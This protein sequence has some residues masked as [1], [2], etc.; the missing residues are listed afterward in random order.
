MNPPAQIEKITIMKINAAMD[1]II[2]PAIFYLF[3]HN[4]E[5]S[6]RPNP[7]DGGVNG[8]YHSNKNKGQ[9]FIK[10]LL[11]GRLL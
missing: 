4:D 10:N 5:N 3:I 2:S 11:L 8:F 9:S 7:L 6:P 1:M